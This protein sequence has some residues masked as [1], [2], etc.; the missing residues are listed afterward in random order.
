MVISNEIKRARKVAKQAAAAAENAKRAEAFMAE[1]NGEKNV[2][3]ASADI[4]VPT[5]TPKKKKRKKDAVAAE[6]AAHAALETALA[7]GD[8][9]ARKKAKKLKRSKAAA[10]DDG[11]GGAT[12]APTSKSKKQKK[13]KSSPAD[14]GDRPSPDAIAAFRAEHAIKVA[15]GTP[16]PIVTFQRAPFPKK[17]IAA[18]LKQGYASPTPIQAQA[19]PIA[20]TGRDV[21]AVAKTGS[22]KTCAFLLPA[23]SRIMKTGASA[24]PDM[25]MVD[26]R[27][28]RVH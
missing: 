22:G 15:A 3:A 14:A 11:D 4:I 6:D 18:L 24:A 20:V 27:F 7:E 16:D 12:A 13:S 10:A 21:I 5:T 25:E 23:L 19:W 26:G 28:R 8:A 9:A 2:G 17:L 1:L